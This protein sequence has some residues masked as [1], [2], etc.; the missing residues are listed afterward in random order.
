L[1]RQVGGLF[2]LENATRVKSDL[3]VVLRQAPSVTDEPARHHE[4][5]NRVHGRN[6]MACREC[7][8]LFNPAVEKKIIT[9]EQR[10]GSLLGHAHE[11]DVDFAVGGRF[12]CPDLYPDDRSRRQHVSRH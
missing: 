4:L 12:Q 11:G 1:D 7:N 2:T 8:K 10:P 6:R 3:S 5:A 9:D